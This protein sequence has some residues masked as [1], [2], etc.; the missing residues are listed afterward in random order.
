M[1]NIFQFVS[2]TETLLQRY[3]FFQNSVHVNIG[4]RTT[5]DTSKKLKY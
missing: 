3:N 2:D 1:V 4:G 5:T